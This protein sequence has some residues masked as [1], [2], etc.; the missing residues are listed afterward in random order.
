[1]R[2][3]TLPCKLHNIWLIGVDDEIPGLL[4]YLTLGVSRQRKFCT[5]DD[6]ISG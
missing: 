2:S 4:S 3:N 6:I 5:Y 1:M